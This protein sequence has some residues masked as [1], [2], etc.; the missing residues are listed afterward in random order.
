[1]HVVVAGAA[2][3]AYRLGD[4]LADRLVAICDSSLREQVVAADV[5]DVAGGRRLHKLEL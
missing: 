3:G 1:M 4:V 2:A 5:V